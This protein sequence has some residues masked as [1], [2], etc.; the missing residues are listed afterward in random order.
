[1]IRVI[2]WAAAML[3]HTVRLFFK[4]LPF[5]LYVW[6]VL[7]IVYGVWLFDE[8]IAYIVG[9]LFILVFLNPPVR[10]KS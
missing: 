7:L 2:G 10:R 4:L 3:G 6:A 5:V 1:M 9:G 8:R